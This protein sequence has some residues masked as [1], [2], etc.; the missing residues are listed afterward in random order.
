MA[1]Y[2]YIVHMCHSFFIHSP[3]DGHLGCFHILAIVNSAAMNIGVHV[4]FSVLVSSGYM[5]S[6]GIA[7][8][9]GGFIPSFLRNLHTIVHSGYINLHSH[10]QCKRVPFAPHPLRPLLF[11]GFLMMAILTGVRWYLILILICISIIMSDVEH[12]FKCLLPI[13]MSSLEK[14]LFRSLFPL[15]DWIFCFWY[16]VVW[17]ACIFW[18]LILCCW[19]YWFLTCFYEYSN[20][21]GMQSIRYTKLY[22][23]QDC[24]LC[25]EISF[26]LL[27]LFHCYG[28]LAASV[29]KGK[30][31]VTIFNHWTGFG[32]N[33]WWA[34]IKIPPAVGCYYLVHMMGPEALKG[35]RRYACCTFNI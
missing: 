9:Y 10:Q 11:V 18:K 27:L 30:C 2:Y 29:G 5:L 16:C 32:F 3:V 19:W 35:I 14:C 22:E 1:E 12:F 20:S 6:R 25:P 31:W 24:H 8:S 15:F 21:E 28:C 4:S 17:A 23:P 33:I 26:S 34:I 7:G 13:W